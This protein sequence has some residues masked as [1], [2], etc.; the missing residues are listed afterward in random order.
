M[1][2]SVF[3]QALQRIMWGARTKTSQFYLWKCLLVQNGHVNSNN[4][5]LD[6]HWSLRCLILIEKRNLTSSSVSW[7]VIVFRLRN[8]TFWTHFSIVSKYEIAWNYLQ[9]SWYSFPY[10]PIFLHSLSNLFFKFLFT[11]EVWCRALSQY[12]IYHKSFISNNLLNNEYL[13]TLL[14]K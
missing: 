5:Q 1:G 9:M 11:N 12:Y 13:L 4:L 10:Q 14:Y 2:F 3:L 8:S 7:F 6:S